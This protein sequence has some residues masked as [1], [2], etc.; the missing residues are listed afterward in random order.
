M[1]CITEP[2]RLVFHVPPF[3]LFT[4]KPLCYARSCIEYKY[5]NFNRSYFQTFKCDLMLELNK[6]KFAKVAQRVVTQFFN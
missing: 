1:Q 3:T 5:D 4:T 6:P 2:K